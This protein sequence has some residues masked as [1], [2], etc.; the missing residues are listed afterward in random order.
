MLI[1]G[2]V[3]ITTG[4][5]LLLQL[6]VGGVSVPTSAIVVPGAGLP[7][8]RRRDRGGAHRRR[9]REGPGPAAHGSG[10]VP[11]AGLRPAGLPP[12]G[13]RPAGLRPAGLPR[14]GRLRA[15]QPPGQP[16]GQA[17]YGGQ[18]GYGAAQPPPQYGGGGQAASPGRTASP[19]STAGAPDPATRVTA[20][21]SRATVSRPL[22]AARARPASGTG[23]WRPTAPAAGPRGRVVRPV[24]TRRRPDPASRSAR[25]CRPAPRR[26]AHR[27]VVHRGFPG[28]GTGRG[29]P[30]HRAGSRREP[31]RP[32]RAGG[33]GRAATVTPNGPAS[34]IASGVTARPDP[35]ASAT[36]RRAD[37]TRPRRAC[38]VSGAGAATLTG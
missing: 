21:R 30:S 33:A 8:D 4:T 2:A 38:P 13:V 31:A 29:H 26:P 22:P 5:L 34:S 15:Q 9:A 24:A 18:P 32:S 37:P 16:S 12:A 28:Y 3:A 19:G 25:R 23:R 35:G 6:V 36:G 7:A 27:D 1:P 17:P 20:G 10:R 14:A 11:A